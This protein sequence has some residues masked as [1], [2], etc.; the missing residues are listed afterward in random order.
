[1]RTIFC[2]VL[3]RRDSTDAR[4]GDGHEGRRI[5]SR[6]EGRNDVST[7]KVGLNGRN[8]NSSVV[9]G[10]GINEGAQEVKSEAGGKKEHGG[11]G[12]RYVVANRYWA[13]RETRGN[14]GIPHFVHSSRPFSIGHGNSRQSDATTTNHPCKSKNCKSA[15]RR[16]RFSD[17]PQAV[18]IRNTCAERACSCIS[19]IT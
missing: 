14:S 2:E 15:L 7:S 8:A 3:A 13:S 1:M 10:L 17:H 19:K 4:I 16:V 12:L 9:A 18:E 5:E 6:E 11:T